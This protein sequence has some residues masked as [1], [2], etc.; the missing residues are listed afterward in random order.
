MEKNKSPYMWM[1]I[2]SDISVSHSNTIKNVIIH[3][4]PAKKVK[5][6]KKGN[7][8][9]VQKFNNISTETNGQRMA[10]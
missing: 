8:G 1:D 3:Y 6:K 2:I 7:K 9:N 4:V 5:I 10:N